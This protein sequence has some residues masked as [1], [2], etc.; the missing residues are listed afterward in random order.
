MSMVDL[1]HSR[2]CVEIWELCLNWLTMA[3]PKVCPGFRALT[4][5][6]AS[7]PFCFLL[8]SRQPLR[9][10]YSVPCMWHQ[11]EGFL[12]TLKLWE[13]EDIRK[14]N[15]PKTAHKLIHHFRGSPVFAGFELSVEA[16]LDAVVKV[17]LWCVTSW[18]IRP[19]KLSRN[20][21]EH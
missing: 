17:T 12:V 21:T 2:I 10:F 1:L 4:C 20:F 6:N 18:K 19:V 15:W 14:S 9:V 13:F 3:C 7:I 8:W 5:I 11:T 16:V